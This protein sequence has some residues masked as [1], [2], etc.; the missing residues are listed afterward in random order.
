VKQYEAATKLARR[1]LATSL[2]RSLRRRQAISVSSL[3]CRN[4][5]DVELGP[6]SSDSKSRSQS[7]HRARVSWSLI[8]TMHSLKQAIAKDE[9][10]RK[11]RGREGFNRFLTVM[12]G[13][14][15]GIWDER[16]ERVRLAVCPGEL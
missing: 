1:V 3:S 4:L 11:T 13:K 9:L 15:K 6:I 5:I 7:S 2:K 8:P 14:G 10:S 12:E 16:D